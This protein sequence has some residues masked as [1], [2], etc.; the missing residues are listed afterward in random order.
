MSQDNG[1]STSKGCFS[2]FGNCSKSNLEARIQALE[3][4]IVTQGQALEQAFANGTV[5][6]DVSMVLAD[7]QKIASVLTLFVPELISVL[8]NNPAVLTDFSNFMTIVES[9]LS[10]ATSG[11]GVINNMITALLGMSTASTTATTVPTTPVV[12]D[13]TSV[14]VQPVGTKGLNRSLASS[15]VSK[16]E[17]IL[18][19]T[20]PT[21]TGAI[22]SNTTQV[23]AFIHFINTIDNIIASS[24]A[25]NVS[26]SSVFV[27][28]ANAI[29]T[30]T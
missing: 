12:P 22:T 16:I 2:C 17:H 27:N 25:N 15:I 21:I 6:A 18:T 5:Q 26:I 23:P 11:F 14:S 13:S 7:G 10:K 8:T 24:K 4:T 3:Q 30:I 1:I 9:V 19:I 28:M 20:C 29:K